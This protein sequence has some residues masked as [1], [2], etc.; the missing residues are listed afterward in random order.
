MDGSGK[1]NNLGKQ[2]IGLGSAGGS[3]NVT[4]SGASSTQSMLFVAVVTMV[5]VGLLVIR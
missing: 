3:V 5:G 2:Y 1:I 4:T